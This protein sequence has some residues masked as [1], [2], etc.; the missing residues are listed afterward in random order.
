MEGMALKLLLGLT[1]VFIDVL[2]DNLLH[3]KDP[4]MGFFDGTSGD[5]MT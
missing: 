1:L 4:L 5:C 3:D 2:T